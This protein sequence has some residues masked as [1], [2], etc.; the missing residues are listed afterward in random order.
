MK[1][2]IETLLD[3]QYAR[4]VIKAMKMKDGVPLLK[5]DGLEMFDHVVGLLMPQD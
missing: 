2:C 4:H 3:N 5:L 1:L